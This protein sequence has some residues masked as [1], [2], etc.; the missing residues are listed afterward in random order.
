MRSTTLYALA[1]CPFLSAVDLARYS[2]TGRPS[3]TKALLRLLRRGEAARLVL[4]DRHGHTHLYYLTPRGVAA[5]A[6]AVSYDPFA[7][8]AYY[9]LTEAGLRQRLPTL[10]RLVRSRRVLLALRDDLADGGGQ[11]RDWLSYPVRWRYTAG[12]RRRVYR[13]DGYGIVTPPTGP[14]WPVG[15]LWDGDPDEPMAFLADRLAR[16]EAVRC[17]PEYGVGRRASVPPVLL[18]TADAA[19]V[20]R[21][22]RPGLLWTTTAEIACHGPLRAPWRAPSVGR[23]TPAPLLEALPRVAPPGEHRTPTDYALPARDP[24]G[25]ASGDRPPTGRARRTVLTLAEQARAQVSDPLPARPGYPDLVAYALPDAPCA[26]LRAVGAHPGLTAFETA[27]VCGVSVRK[28]RER[29]RVCLAQALVTSWA[30]APAHERRYG[31]TPRGTRVLAARSAVSPGLYARVHA[32]LDDKAVDEYG[33][34][35]LTRLRRNAAHTAAVNAVYLAFLRGARAR[36]GALTWRGEW[37]CRHA[38]DMGPRSLGGWDGELEGQRRCGSLYPDAEARYAGPAP[39]SRRLYYIEVDRDTEGLT[40]ARGLEGKFTRY[41][42]YRRD[43]ARRAAP[44]PPVTV[45]FVTTTDA[46]A[47][48]TIALTARL[49]IDR[50]EQPLDLHA[51]TFAALG[52]SDPWA[53]IWSDLSGAPHG[54]DGMRAAISVPALSRVS[55]AVAADG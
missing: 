16:L 41:L 4:P 53:P 33:K 49:A 37:A 1:Q 35:R 22:Y 3:A 13:L 36:G 23:I 14:G 15:Y 44:P 42:D 6:A 55:R 43:L 28:A 17:A 27:T 30:G 24:G 34:G 47:T 40:G 7:L 46:R 8:A 5:A 45:L 32:L 39:G 9:Q 12:V 10:A 19:R 48:A 2:G 50:R 20:P 18:V 21:D 54:L 25:R 29:L 26:V 31:L 52:R 51:T 11:L 38:Y